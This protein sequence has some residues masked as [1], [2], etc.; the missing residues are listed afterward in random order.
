[1]T[2]SIW[3]THRDN[4]QDITKPF[5]ARTE[6]IKYMKVLM[7]EMGLKFVKIQ[8]PVQMLGPHGAIPET[9]PLEV[10]SNKAENELRKRNVAQKSSSEDSH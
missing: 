7:A 9:T 5:N 4:W 1:M 8:Q 2:Y 6:L 3:V 10:P